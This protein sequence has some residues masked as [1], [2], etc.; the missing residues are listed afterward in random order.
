MKN[1]IHLLAGCLIILT[2]SCQSKAGTE[3]APDKSQVCVSDSLARIIRI[4]TAFSSQ[5]NTEVK[6]SG[7]VSFD[8][9]KVVKVFPFSSGQVQKVLVS[10]GDRVSKGQTLAIIKSAD[11]AGNYSDLSAASNDIAIAK[12]QLDNQEALYHNGISSEREFLEAKE[13]YNKAVSNASKIRDQ[14]NINGSGQTNAGGQYLIK[15]PINGYVVEKNA[16]AGSFIRNDNSQNLFTVGDI[17]DVWIWANVYENDVAKVQEGYEASVTTLAYPGRIFKGKVD[18]ENQILDPQ[19]KVMRVRI[20]LQN[21]SLLLKP[22]MFASI[23]VQNQEKTQ[24]VA[25]PAAAIV[26]DNGK[27]FLIIYHDNCHLELRQVDILK[28]L[29]NVTYIN[30]GIRSGEKI[31]SRNQIL[32]YRALIED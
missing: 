14:I 8:D 32:L 16:E 18:K 29:D 21:D 19:T 27:S 25:V 15:S 12:K 9:N 3:T 6:L 30:K 24:S 31:I 10:L 1:I 23:L 2:V 17:G 13:T 26:N 11:V 22:E 7:E 5:V 20:T 28:T 4:D